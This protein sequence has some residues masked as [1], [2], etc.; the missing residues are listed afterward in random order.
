M[1]A[2]V[3]ACAL[4][5]L[6]GCRETRTP[7]LRVCADPDNLP[8]S[9]EQRLGFE[10]RLA[11]LV[12]DEMG[13]RVEYVWW[14]QRRGFLRNTLNAERCEVVMGLPA[15]AEMA[16][17]TRPYYRS[18]YTFVSRADRRLDVDALDDERL[19]GLRIGVQLIGDDGANSP[20]A[21][22]LSRRGIVKNVVGFPVYADPG[23][24]VHAVAEGTVDIAVV[25]G[26][27]AGYVSAREPVPL[28]VIPVKPQI[29]R[30]A[31]PL[32]FDISMAVR[33]RDIA[34]RQ[35]LDDIIERR[36]DELANILAEYHVPR[37]DRGEG[38]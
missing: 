30:P 1:R 35:Q 16:L 13:A 14:P 15:A 26:P 34:L 6:N 10:N 38:Y 37:V 17:T 33:T 36:H 12:A 32:A 23:R 29:D 2:I 5:L 9:N 7:I 27:L 20:P 19:R 31:L 4:L 8:Y 25:W 3:L 24:I 21:H 22:A 28:V 18:T 11:Q